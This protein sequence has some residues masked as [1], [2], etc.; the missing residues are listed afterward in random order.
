MRIAQFISTPA[1][2]AVGFALQA[3]TS[4]L[5]AQGTAFTYQGRLATGGSPATGLY[6]LQFAVYDSTNS[7]GTLIAGPLTVPGTGVTNGLFA[8][9][10]DFGAGV[11]NGSARWLQIGV[12]TNGGGSFVTL[13]PRQ[14][15]TPAP[16]AIF[17]GSA[18]SVVGTLS[19]NGAGVSNVNAVSLSGLAASGFWQTTGNS[20]TG[21]GKYVGTADNQPL[22]LRVNGQRA[23]RLEPTASSQ[24]NVVGGSAANSVASGVVAATIGG[25]DGQNIHSGGNYSVLSGGQDNLIDTNSPNSAIVGGAFNSVLQNVDHSFIGG[26]YFN[27][28]IPYYG[29]YHTIG[30]GQWNAIE[31]VFS[32]DSTIGG[33]SYNETQGNEDTV[34]G[35]T[36]N[37]SGGFASAVPGGANNSALGDYSFAAG[38]SAQAA[39]TGAFVW[40]DAAGFPFASSADNQFSVRATG[41]ARFVSAVDGA[42][43]PTAGASL[44]PGGT[45]WG[46]LSDR[47]V[48]K[49][50][51]P[52]DGK[53]VLDKL[54]SVPVQQ[55]HYQWES[56]AG[57]PNIGP[58]AQDF[59]QAFYPGRNDTCITTLEF[60]GV[61]LAAIQGLD[62]KL[63]EKDAEI[64][65]LKRSVAELRKLVDNLTAQHE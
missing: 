16:Y 6:D 17:A 22:E 62:Q 18:N 20:G 21:P 32:L 51:A 1:L 63:K 23:L 11:F 33:G 31:G 27:I 57:A 43:N 55:W 39:H 60:D 40:A 61:E 30:G 38:N 56:S 46:V 47:K 37:V 42:G 45:A 5:H 35:G 26:G 7:P 54:A 15:L 59:M 44:A 53:A 36:T 52:V 24:P 9:T 3:P 50:F 12:R 65:Q 58:M 2:L 64:E 34:A 48:K 41:G 49:D 10:L 8:V 29:S 13:T 28:V 4:T 14:A 25:G 19:G